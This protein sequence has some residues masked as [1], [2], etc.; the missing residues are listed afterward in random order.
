MRICSLLPSATEIVFSLGLGDHLV[1]VTHECDFPLETTRLPRI[2]RSAIDQSGSSSREIDTHI[3]QAVHGGSSIYE[4]DRDLLRK[5]DPELILTQELCDVC[6]V[7]YGVVQEAVRI[8]EGDRKV[9]SLEPTCL[10][11]ILQSI[12]QVGRFTGVEERASRLVQE[13]QKRIDGI[14]ATAATASSRPRVLALE[15]LDPP[16]V[17][18]HWVPEMVDVAGGTDGLGRKG[19]PSFSVSWDQ[20]ADYDPEIIVALPCGFTLD[21]TIKEM[22]RVAFPEAWSHLGAV[23]AAR[24]YAVDG[25]AYFNRPGPRIVEG[26]EILAEIIHPQLFPQEAAPG[27]WQR[28]MEVLP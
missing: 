6:A 1:A 7:S 25:S 22:G 14:G 23:C 12:E 8:L 24:V 16:F 3:S 18:G 10:S 13:L 4:L 27:R 17:G 26:L 15:W 19:S 11:E 28:L 21:R 5:L 2:T 20:I 9:L